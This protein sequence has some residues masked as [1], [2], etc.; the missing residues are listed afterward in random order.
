MNLVSGDRVLSALRTLAEHGD[1]RPD[2]MSPWEFVSGPARIH[3]QT[4]SLLRRHGY[5]SLY[6]RGRTVTRAVLTDKGR[7]RMDRP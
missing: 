7:A 1:A 4:M 5:V 6:R 2:P 3:G